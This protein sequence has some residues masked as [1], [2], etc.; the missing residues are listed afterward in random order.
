LFAALKALRSLRVS[1]TLRAF[2]PFW[3]LLGGLEI[4]TEIL[5]P[6]NW[7]SR[8]RTCKNRIFR[9]ISIFSLDNIAS[10]LHIVVFLFKFGG[11]V[12]NEADEKNTRTDLIKN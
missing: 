6:F 4:I 7:R 1:A 11:K 2:L 12:N 5:S 3:F 9:N 8:A 10:N